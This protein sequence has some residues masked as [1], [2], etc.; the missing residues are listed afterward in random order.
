[1]KHAGWLALVLAAGCS[2]HPVGDML[3]FFKPGRVYTDGKT[4]PYGGVCRNQGPALGPGSGG[5]PQ[6]NV[7][8]PAPIAPGEPALPVVPPAVPITVGP[9]PAGPGVPPPPPPPT[10]P[11]L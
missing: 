8:P 7:G 10:F 4:V 6:I 9:G 1:M 5:P 3:D 2:T 11:R